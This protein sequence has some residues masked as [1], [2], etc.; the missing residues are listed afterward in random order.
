MPAK[1]I[2]QG[3]PCTIEKLGNGNIRVTQGGWQFNPLI[4]PGTQGEV[5]YEVHPCQR[6]QY[7]VLNTQLPAQEQEMP[8]GF[9][10]DDKPWWSLGAGER[11]GLRD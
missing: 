1:I 10:V 2:L 9:N 6:Q 3:E 8:P 11:A 5:W 4:G 7:D